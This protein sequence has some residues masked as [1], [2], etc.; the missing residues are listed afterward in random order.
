MVRGG[1]GEMSIGTWLGF[2]SSGVRGWES[3]TGELRD[4][5]D[6]N[7]SSRSRS[8]SVVSLRTGGATSRLPLPPR[9]EGTARWLLNRPLP[10]SDMARRLRRTRV[11]RSGGFLFCFFAGR[12]EGESCCDSV[13]SENSRRRTCRVVMFERVVQV[14]IQ[15][16][17]V[18]QWPLRSGQ[19]PKVVRR[20]QRRKRQPQP[21][22]RVQGETKE[23]RR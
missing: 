7:E 13:N 9:K 10:K 11:L 22:R 16:G 19:G 3:L 4:I 23:R 15:C 12:G 14:L 5:V 1:A 17:A 20:V 18:I 6:A 8:T 2:S 21:P